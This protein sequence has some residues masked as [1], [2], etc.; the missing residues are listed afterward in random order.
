MEFKSIKKSE[1]NLTEV[2]I[3]RTPRFKIYIMCIQD[4][5]GTDLP[6]DEGDENRS[7]TSE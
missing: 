5:L 1:R 3:Y 4:K 6:E 2:K 7:W